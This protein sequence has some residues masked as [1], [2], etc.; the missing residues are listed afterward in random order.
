MKS[1]AS[2]AGSY[3]PTGGILAARKFGGGG[4]K[5]QNK[6]KVFQFGQGNKLLLETEGNE[7][8]TYDDNMSTGDVFVVGGNSEYNTD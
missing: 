8:D 6:G 4:L 5:N 3:N 1:L 2:P 7:S